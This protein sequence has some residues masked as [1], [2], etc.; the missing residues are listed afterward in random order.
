MTVPTGAI[1][2]NLLL[3]TVWV[4]LASVL[5]V[6]AAFA[7]VVRETARS[8][9]ARRAGAGGTAMLH[10]G[11]AALFLAVFV[12]IVVVGLVILLRK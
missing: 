8:T 7:L 10:A 1:D 4:S 3:N 5:V 12:G 9:E 2:F 6:T 11:L